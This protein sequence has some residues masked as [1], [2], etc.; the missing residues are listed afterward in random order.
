MRLD[1]LRRI[2]RIRISVDISILIRVPVYNGRIRHFIE[3][4]II[5]IRKIIERI[6]HLVLDHIVNL[7]LPPSER[8][9]IRQ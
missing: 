6:D 3:I 5:F 9:N 8:N 7:W 2:S 4:R 1:C